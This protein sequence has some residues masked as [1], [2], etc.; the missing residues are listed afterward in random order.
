MTDA[1]PRRRKRRWLVWTLL[2]LGPAL[3]AG[4][5]LLAAG[6]PQQRGVQW[7]LEHVLGAKVEVE[8]VRVW[9]RLRI[10]ALTVFDDE[11]A[12]RRND[13]ACRITGFDLD[14]TLSAQGGR[15]VRSL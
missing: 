15:Y 14:Y 1:S 9:D 8:R 12:R 11:E 6:V 4:G 7:V 13:F 5:V 2:A 10:A 3:V